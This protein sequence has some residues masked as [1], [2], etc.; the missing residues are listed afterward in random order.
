MWTNFQMD[1]S[2]KEV[3]WRGKVIVKEN[4]LEELR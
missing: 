2:E 1:G 3:L 4:D